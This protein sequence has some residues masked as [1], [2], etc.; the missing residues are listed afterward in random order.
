M[1]INYEIKCKNL[2]AV[3]VTSLIAK[4][5][6]LVN[7]NK[8]ILSSFSEEMLKQSIKVLPNFHHALISEKLPPDWREK[9]KE[10]NLQAWH[11]NATY[12]TRETVEALNS[13]GLR[14][15]VYTV[16]DRAV[17]DKMTFWGVD[18]IMSDYPEL[19]LNE[20]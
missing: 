18:M 15:R 1:N 2:N 20:I 17:F 9:A 11:L 3:R 10:M 14:V 4:E 8:I 7:P 5:F 19:F 6:K 13:E 12:L 16:N